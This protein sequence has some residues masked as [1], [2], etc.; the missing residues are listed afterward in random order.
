MI[1]PHSLV[2][3]GLLALP[4]SVAA[5]RPNIVYILADD[6]GYGDVGCYG[7][8]KTETPN[9]DRLASEGMRFTAFYSGSPVSAPARC[10]LLTGFHTGH[11]DIRGND[12]RPERGD[13][14]DF[15]ATE[16][17]STWEGQQSLLPGT[18]TLASVLRQGCYATGIFGKWGLGAPDTPSLPNE[19]GF[20][21]FYGY[22]CQRQAHTYYPSHLWR[23]GRREWL[24]NR[25]INPHREGL[26]AGADPNDLRSYAKFASAIYSPDTIHAEAMSF[27]RDHKDGPFFLY[28][29]TTLPHVP[30]QA[31]QRLVDQYV[32][33]FGTETF[34]NGGP[35]DYFPTR[36]PH[37]TYAAMVSYIDEKVGEIVAFLKK[38]GLYENTLI[39]FS[40]D[41]GPTWNGGT[42]SP[43]FRSAGPFRSERGWGKC[44][45]HEGGIRVPLIVSWPGHVRGGSVSNLPCASYD[46]M[47]TLT[48][49]AG[50]KRP[51]KGDGISFAPTLLGKRQRKEHAYLYWEFMD[52][53]GQQAVRMGPWKALREGIKK[54]D[55][56][57]QLFD[58]RTDSVEQHN[59][60]DGHPD[61][62]AKMRKIMVR[63]HHTAFYPTF[64]TELLDGKH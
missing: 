7:Q 42:A 51:T 34:W 58:L 44:F 18:T 11:A 21:C 37:A 27:M 8:T 30:L 46:M 45:L 4:L 22:N 19:L 63:E 14:W 5:Q 39:I 15:R 23:N 56:A 53:D 38:N 61:I 32:S 9:I 50:C 2:A 12:E 59:V 1:K 17:D 60:A 62:V 48:E 43:W 47:A 36:Y 3:T 6:L 33:K 25:F 26:D 52:D 24:G 20:D 41:N 54:G 10:C 64:R 29:A 13:I 55:M 49:L 40:S 28:Y 31:P 35:G 16:R 57:M